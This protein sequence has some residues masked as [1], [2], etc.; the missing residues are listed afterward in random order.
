MKLKWINLFFLLMTACSG[1]SKKVEHLDQNGAVLFPNGIYR[2]AVELQLLSAEGK[3][4]KNFHFNGIVK[5][6]PDMIQVVGLAPFGMTVFKIEENRITHEVKNEIYISDLKKFEPKITE[7]YSV[8]HELLTLSKQEKEDQDLVW[9][10]KNLQTQLP[11]EMEWT[12]PKTKVKASLQL[13][14]Y[15]EH[16][17]PNLIQINGQKFGVKIKVSEYEI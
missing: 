10:K 2:H 15:D 8:L 14:N 6:S 5:I 17:I 16:Q 7:Y 13:M 11:E 9:K 3:I 12:D 1:H 4:E